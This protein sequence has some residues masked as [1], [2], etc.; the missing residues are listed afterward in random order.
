[1]YSRGGKGKAEE[2]A[3]FVEALKGVRIG[4]HKVQ[5]HR[6]A[7]THTKMHKH[8]N[9]TQTQTLAHTHIIHTN[10]HTRMQA[11]QPPHPLAPVPVALL[12][13]RSAAYVVRR[14]CPPSAAA[15]R[16]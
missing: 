11:Y 16:R 1:M 2:G 13:G 4:A 12:P 9:C 3:W 5:K 6:R 7:R 15:R 14:P 8:T 10:T